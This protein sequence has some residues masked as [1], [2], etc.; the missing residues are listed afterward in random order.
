MKLWWVMAAVGWALWKTRNDLIF[1]NIVI[2]SPKQV[3][4]L[5]LG[6]LKQW[7]VMEKKEGSKKEALVEHLKEGMARW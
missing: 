1:S 6:F 4:Y 5:A 7:T 2:K 3:A